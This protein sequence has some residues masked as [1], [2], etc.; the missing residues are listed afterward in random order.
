MFDKRAN[1]ITKPALI[2]IGK[3]LLTYK[4]QP[5]HVTFLGLF[6]GIFLLQ[7]LVS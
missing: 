7:I 1:Q 2:L 6:V 4:V 5:N 3:I